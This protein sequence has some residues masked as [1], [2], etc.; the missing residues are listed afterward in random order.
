M[1]WWSSIGIPAQRMAEVTRQLDA[2]TLT[3]EIAPAFLLCFA[4]TSLVRPGATAPALAVA[5]DSAT[6]DLLLRFLPIRKK[7]H[8]P[9]SFVGLGR[10]DGNDLC[11]PDP[12]VSKFHAYFQEAAPSDGRTFALVDADSTNGTFVE[13]TRAP[14][15]GGQPLLLKSGDSIRFGSVTTTFLSAEDVLNFIR[16]H[17][18]TR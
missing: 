6:A 3:Q 9:H 8:S 5:N 18:T 10:L 17:I 14:A 1:T 2:S 16:D 4:S 12:S 15:R 11:L 7:D 13:R